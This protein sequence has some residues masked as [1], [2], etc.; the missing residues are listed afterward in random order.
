MIA[1]IINAAL[2]LIGSILGLIFKN[3]ISDRFSTVITQALAL[4]V[5]GIGISNVSKGGTKSS[6]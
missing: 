5:L 2:I 4:C 3:K 1:T 6:K